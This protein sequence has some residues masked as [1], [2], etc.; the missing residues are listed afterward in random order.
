MR[1]FRI[2]AVAAALIAASCTSSDYTRY[3]DG[4][5][6][7]SLVIEQDKAPFKRSVLSCKEGD[8]PAVTRE[9]KDIICSYTSFKGRDIDVTMRFAP[10][11]KGKGV[12][13]TTT[14][15]NRENGI[16][17]K[18]VI[19]PIIISQEIDLDTWDLFM[20]WGPGARYSGRPDISDGNGNPTQ[21]AG[22]WK[23]NDKGIYEIT[24]AYPSSECQMQFL[25]FNNGEKGLYM[26]SHDSGFKFKHFLA[27]Y[28]SNTGAVS[29]GIEHM[30]TCFTGE[31]CTTPA[32]IIYPHDGDWH[33]AADIYS[34]FFHSCMQPV[35]KPDWVDSSTAWML[36]IMKQQNGELMWPYRTIGTT[37]TDIA[38]ERGY[39]MLGLFGWTVGGHDK[40]YPEYDVDPAMGGEQALRDG[41]ALAQERGMKVIMYVNGQLIDTEGTRFWEETGSDIVVRKADGSDYH[42]MWQKYRDCPARHHGM[43]CQSDPRWKEIMLNLAKQVNSYGADGIIFDQLGTKNVTYCYA[44]NHGHKVP[45]IVYENDKAANLKYVEQEMS[46][47]NPEF[48]VITEGICEDEINSISMFHLAAGSIGK[49]LF[50]TDNAVDEYIV[51]SPKGVPFAQLTKYTIPEWTSTNRIQAPINNRE[52]INYCIMCGMRPEIECRYQPDVDYLSSGRIPLDNDYSNMISK[53][54]ITL[55]QSLDAAATREY[56]RQANEFMLANADLFFKG[57]F[58]DTSGYGMESSSKAVRSAAFRNGN[59]MGVVVWNVSREADAGYRIIPEKGWRTSGISAPDCEPAMGDRL[60]PGSIHL[61]MLEK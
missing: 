52:N 59:R 10:Y 61:I 4:D 7:W 48:I 15:T 43:A 42:Q 32:T 47:I 23:R 39:N 36:T 19:G 51:G 25:E 49:N 56:A 35:R 44:P 8:K 60:A 11:R 45:A 54:D 20:P 29:Y 13:I 22:Q 5:L 53:V 31:T 3:A 2:I 28:D 14:V 33:V 26:A 38:K 57:Q 12:E 46:K 6:N 50:L 17:I 27:R 34:D 1:Y 21:R 55:V 16:Y 37:M 58:V 40:Y 18:G 30:M 24:I 41:I 9:G